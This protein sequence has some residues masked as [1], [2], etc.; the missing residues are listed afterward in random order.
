M[1]T[2]LRRVCVG[3]SVQ[4]NKRV[5]APLPAATARFG[6]EL[7]QWFMPLNAVWELSEATPLVGRYNSCDR[8][9]IVQHA[10][11]F[12]QMGVDFLLVD[13]TNNIWNTPHWANRTAGV[14]YLI[15]GFV[16]LLDTYVELQ[17]EGLVPVPKVLLL[18]GLDNG[19]QANMVCLNE[20]IAYIH[21]N[22]TSNP[23]YAGLW[24]QLDGKPLLI[25]FDGANEHGNEW[26]PV[27]DEFFTIRWMASQLQSNGFGNDGLWSWMDGDIAPPAA[28]NNGSAEALT[29]TNAFFAD[30]GWLAPT[31]RG[32][33]GGSTLL[34]EFKQAV[35]LQPKYLV[36]CQWNE[37]IGQPA[38]QGYG[39]N[40]SIY[41]D[42]FNVTFSNDMEPTSL[43]QV[44]YRST[45]GGWGLYYVNCVRALRDLYQ[46]LTNP[47]LSGLPSEPIMLLALA[48]PD[49]Q[50]NIS[51][52]SLLVE[53][54]V[55][56]PYD[57]SAS[58]TTFAVQLNG[59]TVA[60]GLTG[61]SYTLQ[62]SPSDNGPAM[63]S[64]LAEGRVS[65]YP[66]SSNQVDR[67]PLD[68]PIPLAVS[69]SV[70]VDV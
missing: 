34:E 23:K 42:I 29:I 8:D 62:L 52:P 57:G 49:R 41:V 66:L 10:I 1:P 30:G 46:Q 5:I 21:A 12:A 26:P 27:D 54:S 16:C 39:L 51:E 65:Y 48:S 22:L 56:G 60:S 58:N 40:H 17:A 13:W 70:F 64:V 68:Q 20:E 31:A 6:M 4:V 28:I 36:L 35:H 44:G 11:W 43:S 55:I 3:R 69:T 37:F 47:K 7:E 14:N 19:V 25:P 32:Q 61:H 18:L 59:V 67:V 45:R 24:E 38:G 15:Q 63:I 50:Q 33:L 9:V 2:G 53:W